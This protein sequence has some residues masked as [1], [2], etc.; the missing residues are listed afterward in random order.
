M[1]LRRRALVLDH[2]PNRRSRVHELEALVDALEREL[3]RDETVD[4]DLA[5]HVPVDDFRHIGATASATKGRPFPDTPGHE[6]KRA[7]RDLAAGAR[8]ADDDAHAP[9][10]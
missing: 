8:D 9:A 3:V 5:V 7:R 10:A 4:V 1:L 6:L 2:C